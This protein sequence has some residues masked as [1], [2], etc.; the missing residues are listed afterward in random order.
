MIVEEKKK[1][2]MKDLLT[3]CL[4]QPDKIHR[5]IIETESDFERSKLRALLRGTK[6]PFAVHPNLLI[7]NN[8]QDKLER[9]DS[10][11][12]WMMGNNLQDK[13]FLDFGCGEGHVAY[14]ASQ[15][16]KLSIGYDINE[17]G[18]E[19]FK[20]TD[21][22]LLTSEFQEAHRHGPYDVILLY[23]VLDHIMTEEPQDVLKDLRSVL[24]DDGKVYV[25]CHPWCSRHGTHAYKS[26]NK[27]Y[28]HFFFTPEELE[29]MGV[30]SL[31]TRKIIH[32]ITTYDDWFQ[33]AGLKKIDSESNVMRETIEP[34][35]QQEDI[36]C[37]LIKDHWKES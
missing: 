6:W 3:A 12:D 8:D 31:P 15:R 16:A 30:S 4:E 11:L 5:I 21:R 2:R 18:W 33:K 13:K 22:F 26:L 7:A 27:A 9:A 17:T 25:R 29:K 23:D 10:I 20:G 32:P 34:F 24:K 1:E 14:Q 35:F 19:R 28:I 36:L 37:K